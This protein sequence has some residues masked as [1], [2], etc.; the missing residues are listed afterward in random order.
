MGGVRTAATPVA[1]VGRPRS[2]ATPS[3]PGH[4]ILTATVINRSGGPQE[5][6]ARDFSVHDSLGA[7]LPAAVQFDGVPHAKVVQL[8]PGGQVGL[9]ASWRGE[10]AAAMRFGGEPVWSD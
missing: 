5:L 4:R 8:A 6:D 3:L 2:M 9:A 7:R 1:L 10:P